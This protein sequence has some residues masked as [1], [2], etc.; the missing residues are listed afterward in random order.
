MGGTYIHTM[1][2]RD[3]WDGGDDLWGE[4][5][6]MREVGR[7]TW[8]GYD[9]ATHVVGFRACGS[10]SRGGE[11]KSVFMYMY[12]CGCVGVHAS[13]CMYITLVPQVL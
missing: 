3:L 6:V 8:A 5:V 7:G 10:D 1:G 2:V 11:V 13:V 12:V 4:M 9:G